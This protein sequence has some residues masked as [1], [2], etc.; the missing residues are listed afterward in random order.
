[1]R[2]DM[3]RGEERNCNKV[4]GNELRHLWPHGSSWGR[5]IF[6]I[7]VLRG[8]G[9]DVWG[10]RGREGAV[11]WALFVSTLFRLL[12]GRLEVDRTWV[13][14]CCESHFRA[15]LHDLV[16]KGQEGGS[17]RNSE[18]QEPET[19]ALPRLLDCAI[20]NEDLGIHPPLF[21]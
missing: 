3:G 16:C 20:S 21:S 5:S 8:V 15:E 1:M 13:S 7:I 17:G 19:Q 9:I 2:Q 4:I 14:F 6:G 12:Y 18:V 10:A 11:G